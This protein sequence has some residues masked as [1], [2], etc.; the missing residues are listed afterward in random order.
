MVFLL[1]HLIRGCEHA[2]H[3]LAE[4]ECWPAQIER[5]DWVGMLPAHERQVLD[6]LFARGRSRDLRAPHVKHNCTGRPAAAQNVADGHAHVVQQHRPERPAKKEADNPRKLE[7]GE[8]GDG[9]RCAADVA[10]HAQ[11]PPRLA[12]L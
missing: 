2:T 12:S 10:Q 11:L 5:V 4:W 6:R 9:G 1:G 3:G 8:D 7:Q